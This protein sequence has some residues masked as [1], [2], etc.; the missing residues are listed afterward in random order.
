[1][2]SSQLHL[3]FAVPLL[4]AISEADQHR[5]LT[6]VIAAF[7]RT[8]HDSSLALD[9]HH[10]SNPGLHARLEGIG[11]H[12]ALQSGSL[13]FGFDS[14]GFLASGFLTL[15][16]GI[17]AGIFDALE[18]EVVGAIAAV[19]IVD[20]AAY[21]LSEG[22]GAF[23]GATPAAIAAFLK[24]V[25]VRHDGEAHEGVGLEDI[26]GSHVVGVHDRILMAFLGSQDA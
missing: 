10:G 7:H 24:V 21:P 23:H 14:F 1:M 9:R 18:S 3:P 13:V 12:L 8:L 15:Q 6:I 16:Q 26:G 17:R 22:A 19:A 5:N 2:E 11:L 4:G 20:A 25:A